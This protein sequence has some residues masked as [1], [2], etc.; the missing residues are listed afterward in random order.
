MGISGLK[1]KRAPWRSMRPAAKYVKL[2]D[3]LL[4]LMFTP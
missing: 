1:V 2:L 4:A 3:M